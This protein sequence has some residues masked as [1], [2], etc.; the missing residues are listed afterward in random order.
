MKTYLEELWF[1]TDTTRRACLNITPQVAAAV[2][3][4]GI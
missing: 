2:H 3:T 1:Q 4:S